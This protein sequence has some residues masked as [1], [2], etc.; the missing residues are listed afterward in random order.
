MLVSLIRYRMYTFIYVYMYGLA[1]KVANLIRVANCIAAS[2]TA[3]WRQRL[4]SAS[5]TGLHARLSCPLSFCFCLFFY[6]KSMVV[7]VCSALSTRPRAIACYAS[8]RTSFPSRHVSW[9]CLLS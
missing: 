2:G 8:C 3:S 9:T 6:L 5:F 7:C 4:A 1:N